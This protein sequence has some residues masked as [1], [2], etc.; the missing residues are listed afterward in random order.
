MLVFEYLHL[1]S[2]HSKRYL[3][4][5][6]ILICLF[7]WLILFYL[8]SSIPML[9]EHYCGRALAQHSLGF[10]SQHC[11]TR[12]REKRAYWPLP[13]FLLFLLSPPLSLLELLVLGF[14]RQGLAVS[15]S[16]ASTWWAFCL[17]FPS[18]EIKASA[19]EF[20]SSN[21]NFY[22][23]RDDVCLFIVQVNL[24]KITQLKHEHILKQHCSERVGFCETWEPVSVILRD[25]SSVWNSCGHCLQKRLC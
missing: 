21:L 9:G 19:S 16:V 17:N 20:P 6:I 23:L 3:Y 15:P 4:Q 13:L 1:V 2:I 8:L 24:P 12:E 10:Q 11:K 7:V 22:S 18:A 14:L 5:M 25:W